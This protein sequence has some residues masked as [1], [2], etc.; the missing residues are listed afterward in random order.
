MIGVKFPVMASATLAPTLVALPDHGA[1][2]AGFRRG[3][4]ARFPFAS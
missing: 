1:L 3:G 4:R 2:I